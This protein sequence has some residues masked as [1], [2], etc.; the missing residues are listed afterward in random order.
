MAQPCY[1]LPQQHMNLCWAA[2][3]ARADVEL[4]LTYGILRD[5]MRQ[6]DIA[7]SDMRAL[8]EPDKTYEHALRD[9]QRAW[10]AFRDAECNLRKLEVRGGSW[11]PT[12]YS[13]C[14]QRMT[15]ERTQELRL[16]YDFD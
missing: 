2:Q 12:V 1:D 5:R 8:S 4:N 9:A 7:Y 14:L 16:F 6:L 11:V 10:I 15:L 3:A 13:V